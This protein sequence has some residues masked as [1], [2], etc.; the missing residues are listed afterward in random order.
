MPWHAART[1]GADGQAH[2]AVQD[3]VF[4]YAA[5][6][7]QFA[8]AAG[9]QGRQASAAPVLVGNPTGDL[10]LAEAEVATLLRRYY[11]GAAYLGRP[12]ELATGPATPAEL[13]SRLPGGSGPLASLLH[14]GCHA[15]VAASLTESYLVLAGGQKLR[16]ADI[17]GQAQRH[18]PRSPGFLAVLS[19]CMTDMADKDH[20]EALTLASALLAAGA[21]GVIGARWPVPDDATAPFMVMFHHFLSNGQPHPADALR[22]AQLWM[23]DD[24]RVVPGD[25]PEEL[26]SAMA[27]P[28]TGPYFWAAFTHQGA[29]TPAR[30]AN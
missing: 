3:A 8:R 4:S 20:D 12:P 9:R 21:S 22:A 25:L 24:N 7:G 30:P 1:T 28:L 23:L 10:F 2:Y 17:L 14:C 18:D 19:A 6:A 13:L 29:H 26:S 11:P 5:S 27:L 16:V 15:E